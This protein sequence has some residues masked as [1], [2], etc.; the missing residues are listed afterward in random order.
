[1]EAA[2]AGYRLAQIFEVSKLGPSSIGNDEIQA[3]ELLDRF[4]HD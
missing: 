1:M 4:L 2:S 3:I